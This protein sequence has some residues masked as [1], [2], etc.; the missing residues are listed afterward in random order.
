MNI[1]LYPNC[2]ETVFHLG[3]KEE[4]IP[5]IKAR[6]QKLIGNNKG[7]LEHFTDWI[8]KA[9]GSG[10]DWIN[11][12]DGGIYNQIKDELISKRNKKIC[13]FCKE[14][15]EN[16][17]EHLKKFHTEEIKKVLRY[18]NK[19]EYSKIKKEIILDEL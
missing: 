14:K 16:L 4:E 6:I 11:E 1:K 3:I 8:G 9:D 5:Y 12:G 2:S 13:P 18:I 7:F 17:S 15:E 10:N 19:E